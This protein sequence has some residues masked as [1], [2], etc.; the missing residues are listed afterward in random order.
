M[1]RPS[2]QVSQP[3][4]SSPAVTSRSTRTG[5]G[6]PLASASAGDDIV[7]RAYGDIGVTGGLTTQG[8]DVATM[9][10]PAQSGDL[11]AALDPITSFGHAFAL[12]GSSIDLKAG[13]IVTVQNALTA[14]GGASDIRVQANGTGGMNLAAATADE[15]VLI[16]RSER[17]CCRRFPAGRARCRGAGAV[18]HRLHLRERGGRHRA[19]LRRRDQCRRQPDQPW[20]GRGAE[21]SSE[22]GG[23]S[24]LRLRSP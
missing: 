10:Q 24:A 7:L 21:R 14:A 5:A 8:L 11:L 22:P 9:S 4:I 23:R 20:H 15:D 6:S 12:T 17:S 13:S 3:P 19:S 1:R 2:A 16:R 18:L